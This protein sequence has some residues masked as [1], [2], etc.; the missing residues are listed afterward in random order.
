[1]TKKL[2]SI[3]IALMILALVA[4]PAAAA[5]PDKSPLPPGNPFNIIW[6]L[7]QNLQTQIKAVPAVVL[8][9]G[10]TYGA[11]EE[12]VIPVPSDFTISQCSFIFQEQSV[13]N[14]KILY[15]E[16][17][18]PYT[19]SYLVRE[20]VPMGNHWEINIY[21]HYVPDDGTGDEIDVNA[22]LDYTII[23]VK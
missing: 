1:M 13:T 20:A 15:G 2:L 7:L 14:I 6:N 21:T 19:A 17:P 11:G 5:L 23:C 3:G 22:Y 10:E 9:Q 18:E 4:A 16:P 12:D 8:V